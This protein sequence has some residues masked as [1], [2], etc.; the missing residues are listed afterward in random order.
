M[1]GKIGD[2]TQQAQAKAP[3][4]AV[5]PKLSGKGEFERLQKAASEFE[6]LFIYEMLKGARSTVEKSDFFGDRKGEEIY[7]SMLDLEYSKIMSEGNGMGL[8]DALMDQFSSY[9]ADKG[10]DV[11]KIVPRA[12]S[13]FAMKAY[14]GGDEGAQEQGF[15][16]PVRGRVSSEYGLREDPITHKDAFHKGMDIAAPAGTKVFAAMPGTVIFSGDKGGYGNVVEI[17]HDNG[18]VSVYGH[19]RENLV[20][21]GDRVDRNS[22]IA[23]VGSTGRSTG[24]HL[25]FEIR[26]E[27]Y[28]VNPE[29]LLTKG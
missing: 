5:A 19:N 3:N 8:K 29:E 13:P 12:T 1:F 9:L 18:H 4:E 22:V 23:T 14:G 15:T 10:V 11:P 16:L 6:S 26:V 24:P 2:I 25:H 17:K 20:K 27:G 21:A 28:A 7:T